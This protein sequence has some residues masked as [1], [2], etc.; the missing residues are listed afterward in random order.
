MDGGAER[1]GLEGRG[2]VRGAGGRD[3]KREVRSAVGVGS[4]DISV[5]SAG[6]P[7]VDWSAM[8][9]VF[10]VLIVG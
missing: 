9:Q 3:V 4:V 10:K 1:R 7:R 6:R 5:G 8:R 2:P